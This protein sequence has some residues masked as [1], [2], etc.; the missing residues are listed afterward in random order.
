MSATGCTSLKLPALSLPGLL[1]GA[2]TDQSQYE[3]MDGSFQLQPSASEQIYHS[4]QRARSE[5][6]IVLEVVGD[7]T[8][9]RV[10]PLPPGNKAVYVS[11]LLEQT[12]VR[13]KLDTVKATLYRHSSDSIGGIPM[14]VKMTRDARR[15]RP[16]SDYALQ[17][18][19][20]LRVEK[21][22]SP[23]VAQL[24]NAVLGR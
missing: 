12:G 6:A 1:P 22:I 2:S 8:P 21:A 24:M 4:V 18:G 23:V 14:D 16:E 9:V 13:K 5:N 20:R 15:V 10:L 3:G 7:S 19:D 11:N 17:A